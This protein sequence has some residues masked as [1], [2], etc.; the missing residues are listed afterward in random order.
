MRAAPPVSVPL[1]AGRGLC[2]LSASLHAVACAALAAWAAAW[3][4]PER[5]SLPPWWFMLGAAIFVV[6]AAFV[7]QGHMRRGLWPADHQLRWTGQAWVLHAEAGSA[8]ADASVQ[9]LQVVLDL[10]RWLLLR[11]QSGTG[12]TRRWA[13]V[14]A[15]S[16]G[17]GWHVARVA[18]AA[19]VPW[20]TRP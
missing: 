19:H 17:D 9:G 8:S 6:L 15:A 10:D 16:C 3:G 1:G 20:P 14:S 13:T 18:L 11:L 7:G 2:L 12:G 4:W 5:G